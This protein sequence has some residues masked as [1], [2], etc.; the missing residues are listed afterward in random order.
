MA[1]S[2]LE[3]PP[4]SGKTHALVALARERA[5]AGERI[6][7]VCPAHARDHALRVLTR[8][9]PTW[10]VD[11]WTMQQ[12]AYRLAGAARRSNPLLTGTGRLATVAVA[13]TEDR[14]APPTPGEAR[15]FARAI[16]EAKR[17]GVAGTRMPGRDPEVAR[18]RRVARAYER[19]KGPAWD[20]DD[21]VAH[22][23]T[24]SSMPDVA[25]ALEPDRIVVDGFATLDAPEVRMLEA[26]GRH[27][28]VH[29]AVERVP[30]G[31]VA[32]ASTAPRPARRH[33]YRFP[34]P[35]AEVRWVLRDVKAALATGYGPLDLAIVVPRTLARSV[36]LVA[37]EFGIPIMDETPRGLAD[38]MVGRRLLDLLDLA[39][40]PTG[41]RLL[42]VPH[43]R[44]LGE[45]VL[46]AGV[47]G[48][49]PVMRLAEEHGMVDVWHEWRERLRVPTDP[50]TWLAW[51]REMVDRAVAMA[52]DADR[53]GEPEPDAAT[54]T[55][56]DAFAESAA[57]VLVEARR[58][59]VDGDGL[60]AWWSALLHQT[61]RSER[62]VAGV[63]LLIPERA[64]G[65]AYRRAWIVGAVHG[66]YAVDDEEDY[67]VPEEARHDEARVL[68]GGALPRRMQGMAVHRA[69][70]LLQR[71]EEVTVTFAEADRGGSRRPDRYLVPE[72]D[73]VDDPPALPA[74]SLMEV[75]DGTP[76]EPPTGPVEMGEPEVEA[77]A[78]HRTC[79]FKRWAEM[80]LLREPDRDL[81]WWGALR[82]TL[83][84]RRRWTEEELRD[85]TTTFPEAADWMTEHASHAATFRFGV[86]I[87]PSRDG[88]FARVDA[89]RD[90]GSTVRVVTI[91]GPGTFVDAASWSRHV[92]DGTRAPWVVAALSQVGGVPKRVSL[93]V[94]QVQGE[95]YTFPP[96]G[97]GVKATWNSAKRAVRE[98]E[99]A[100]TSWRDGR[101]APTP[102]FACRSCAVF[103]LC[104]VGV[105]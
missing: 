103:D 100:W 84:S 37:D 13:L 9:G 6:W 82:R 47:A 105:R 93:D 44:A 98:V 66:A 81:P 19:L 26:L 20:Y 67:F 38:S 50:D 57:L 72:I 52:T 5:R 62:P 51:G 23:T 11:A 35:V 55:T 29:V 95:S 92:T 74:G 34:N 2:F 40:H 60:R 91:A 46:D 64:F 90:E 24:W 3:G 69:H 32:S 4:G 96:G 33:T 85:L 99:E 80:R 73:D 88:P 39:E 18:L 17:Y 70:A 65:R 36:A 45:R 30:A 89:M 75:V 10:G 71:G 61:V 49:G 27:L 78:R 16:A 102:G 104:R 54:D 97:S 48:H 41:P 12:V 87:G 53:D 22:A 7:W 43:L 63:A 68:R 42:S 21:F 15:L 76:Y 58:V 94:W 28:P 59:A 83:T 79:G 101:A 77:L 8:D 31:R 25:P 86:R 56:H 14:G 1:V